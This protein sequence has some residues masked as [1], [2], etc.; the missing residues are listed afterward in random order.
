MNYYIVASISRGK[1]HH[2]NILIHFSPLLKFDDISML[3]E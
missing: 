2:I 3:T 1:E